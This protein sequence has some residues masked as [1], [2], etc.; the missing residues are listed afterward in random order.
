MTQNFDWTSFL[1]QCLNGYTV[2]QAPRNTQLPEGLCAL[3]LAPKSASLPGIYRYKFELED[4]PFIVFLIEN[5]DCN[6][7]MGAVP[8]QQLDSKDLWGQTPIQHANQIQ[9]QH[10][11]E[12]KVFRHPITAHEKLRLQN[13]FSKI[14]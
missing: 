10:H 5:P 6:E 13:T 9:V 1:F 2:V 12:P 8:T 14:L 3:N 11:F 7:V 4:I